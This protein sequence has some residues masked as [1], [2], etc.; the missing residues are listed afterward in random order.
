MKH[1]TLN[2]SQFVFYHNTKVK[3]KFFFESVTKIVTQRKSK[4][5]AY[6]FLESDWFIA[7]NDR[8]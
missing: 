1:T 4:R 3:E 8:S 6:N 5:F 2:Q 7:Q